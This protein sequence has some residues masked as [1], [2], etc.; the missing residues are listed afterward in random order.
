M[1]FRVLG[2]WCGSVLQAYLARKR[3]LQEETLLATSKVR[4]IALIASGVL[5]LPTLTK[6]ALD[7]ELTRLGFALNKVTPDEVDPFAYLLKMPL[8]ALTLT[9]VQ[10]LSAQEQQKK[11]E[12]DLV[13][14][15]LQRMVP[16]EAAGRQ[17]REAA[18]VHIQSWLKGCWAR[19]F[20]KRSRDATALIQAHSRGR[21]ARKLCERLRAS[22]AAQ[23]LL[24]LR[25]SRLQWKAATCIQAHRRGLLA[26]R[27]A[28]ALSGLRSRAVAERRQALL[29]FFVETGPVVDEAH[30]EAR[31]YRVRYGFLEEAEEADS[32]GGSLR[33]SKSAPALQSPSTSDDAS[34][35]AGSDA[36]TEGEDHPGYLWYFEGRV[37]DRRYADPITQRTYY[38]SEST[39]EFQYEEDHPGVAFYEEDGPPG[40]P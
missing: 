33:R 28:A 4:F 3:Q 36:E 22:A 14:S 39:Q 13:E 16:E 25:L 32:D 31:G 6:D 23:R 34:S 18:A 10:E 38:W 21:M 5:Q 27:H 35:L 26:R 30:L 9:E 11:A 12:L 24:R 17:H 1:A 20:F 37:W 8:L 7:M 40:P 29:D 2:P 15:E 19:L